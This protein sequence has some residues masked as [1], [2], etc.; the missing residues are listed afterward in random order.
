LALP[1]RLGALLEQLVSTRHPIAFLG[2]RP[3]D[4]GAS[5]TGELVPLRS[6]Q[7]EVGSGLADLRTILQ[8]TD[9]SRLG[10]PAAQFEAMVDGL[11]ADGVTSQALI[12]AFLHLAGGLQG[13][14]MSHRGILSR[15]VGLA[16][17]PGSR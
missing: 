4:L 13:S 16:S 9:V 5:T 3:A 7:H 17:V 12:D 8:Q 6:P 11:D 10:M 14:L 2:T 1:T 15:R